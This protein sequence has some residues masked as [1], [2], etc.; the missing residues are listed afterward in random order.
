MKNIKQ[1]LLL[2]FII[3]SSSIFAQDNIAN[4][5]IEPLQENI[6]YKEKVFLHINKSVYFT[7]ETIWV[8]AYVAEDAENKPSIYTSNLHL[9][10]VDIDGN[11]IEHKTI[12]I[13]NGVGFGDFLLDNN[14]TSGKYYIQGS[15][16]YMRNFGNEN[17][18]IQEIEIINSSLKKNENQDKYANSYDIQLFPESGYLLENTENTLGIKALIN[19]KGFPFSGKITN[20]KG[21]VVNNFTGNK[22]GMGKCIFNYNENEIYT[23]VVNINNTTQIINIPKAKKTGVIFSVDNSNEEALILTLKT[24]KQTLSSLQNSNLA[25]LFYRNNYISQAVTLSLINTKETTQELVFSK[26][27][28]LNGV[29]VVT[30]FKNNQPIAERKFFV[31]KHSEQTAILIEELK[32]ENDSITYKVKTLNSKSAPISTQLSISVLPK[33]SKNFHENQTIKSAFLLTPYVK[34]NIENPSYYFENSNQKKKEF[35]DLLLLN[36]GWVAYSLE[37]K[38]KE[39]NPIEFY[40]FESGF[41]VNGNI[42]SYPKGYNIGVL[43]KKGGLIASSEINE[44]HDFSFENVFNYK[45]D[46]LK[47]TLIKNKSSLVKPLKVSFIADSTTINTFSFIPNRSNQN[48]VIK[49]ISTTSNKESKVSNFNNYPNVEVLNQVVLKTVKSKRKRTFYDDEMDLASKHKVIAAGFYDN[50]KITE[51]ME[52]T[53]I[54]LLHYF[55]QL[56][57]VKGNCP[58]NCALRLREA[59]K[60]FMAPIAKPVVYIDGVRID[61]ETHIEAFELTLME[62]VDEILI[63]RSGAGGGIDASGGIVKIYLKKA[64]HKYYK[65]GKTLYKELISLTGFDKANNYFKPQYNIYTKEAYNW[66]EIDWKS[67][68]QTNEKGEVIIKVPTNEFSNDFQFIIN[69]FSDDGLLFNTVYKTGS[70]N[71]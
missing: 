27:K 12:F 44:E 17:V 21:E 47:I 60:S 30:L 67:N 32:T 15:T 1:N 4:S 13:Q 23:A 2:L 71:F 19:G 54:H 37:E 22:L 46:S 31:D 3:Y 62:D 59:R 33:N 20:S 52:D 43:S 50:K 45:N 36:Q 18:F 39:I 51:G 49:P 14:L 57:M 38:R 28:M 24:N 29:N 70:T 10:L 7:N 65:Y 58:I 61:E 64:N 41:T 34:G 56:G 40:K 48:P 63:N 66:T 69:G 6:L 26:S 16:N 68:L 53:Y 11:L 8:N 35:L 55:Q 42:K 5:I 9:N 25:L